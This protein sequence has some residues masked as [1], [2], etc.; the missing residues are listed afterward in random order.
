MSRIRSFIEKHRL[1][2]TIV[3]PLLPNLVGSIFNIWYNFSNIKPLLTEAQLT[4]FINAVSIYNAIIYPVLIC[5]YVYWVMSLKS[6]QTKLIAGEPVE[7]EELLRAQRKV[8]NLPW[9]IATIGCIGWF[10]CIPVFLIVMYTSHE[11]LNPHIKIHLPVSFTIAGLIAITQGFFI[12]ELCSLRLLYPTFFPN[13]GA[14]GTKGAYSLG[15]IG[16]GLIWAVSAVVCPVVCL[17]LL[18]V[19][20]DQARNSE[21]FSF[22]AIAVSLVAVFFG[23]AS[24]VMMGRLVTEPVKHLRKAAQRV[25]AGD[26]TARANIIRADDFG[27][28]IDEFNNMVTGL[29]EK[30]LI[31][32]TFGRHVGEQAAREILAQESGPTGIQKVISVMFCDLRNFTARSSNMAAAEVV[33]MLN[34][35]LSDMV[36]IVERHDGMVNKF[37]G[38][39]FMALF[40]AGQC[41][42]SH[43]DDSVAAGLEMLEKMEGI[44]RKLG[45]SEL[46]RLDIGIGI[47][48]GPA[49][50]GS[51][52]SLKR[53][54]YTAIGDTVNV[55]SRIESL[56]KQVGVPLLITESTKIHLTRDLSCRE[57]PPQYVKGKAEAISVFTP[58]SEE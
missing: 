33:S 40:G 41:S 50:V 58:V 49:I 53:L 16:K 3:A 57:L 8:I 2:I 47:H 44:N 25:G 12:T 30:A 24:A 48:T 10:L 14:A 51:I 27:P 29:N 46:K 20:P 11:P 13:G 23:L 35:F 32:E 56:T 52:G 1:S 31:Q 39:G 42:G 22:F 55:A 26:L 18:F 17:L 45:H 38:D 5:C 54:E 19:A 21:W 28:L 7:P 15:L 43:A 34:L 37:L 36:E 9:G 6:T 4:R